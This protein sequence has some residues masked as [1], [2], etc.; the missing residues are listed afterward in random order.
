MAATEYPVPIM[1]HPLCLQ[2]LEELL[3]THAG[4]RSSLFDRTLQLEQRLHVQ[5]YIQVMIFLMLSRLQLFSYQSFQSKSALRLLQYI[6]RVPADK[7][8]VT[9][10]PVTKITPMIDPQCLLLMNDPQAS[11]EMAI[12]HSVGANIKSTSTQPSLI[13][14]RTTPTRSQLE[15]SPLPNSTI[16]CGS[17]DHNGGVIS[18]EDGI[19][20]TVPEGAIKSGDLVTFHIAAGLFG[21]F[22]LLSKC[23]ANLASPYY[24]IGVSGSYHFHKPVQVEFEHFGACDPS[25]YQLLCCEDDDESCTLRPVDYELNFEERDGLSLCTFYTHHFCSYCL[26]HGCKDPKIS[27]IV[28]LY[29]RPTNFQYLNYFTVEIWFSLPISYCLKRSEELFRMR[30]MSLES[31]SIFVAPSKKHSTIYFTLN[32]DKEINGWSIHHSRSTIIKTTEVNFYNYNTNAKDLQAMEEA[33][34]FPP[35]FV[36][37]VSKKS[38]CNT[39]LNTGVA[40]TLRDGNE[41]KKSLIY[42]LF[43]PGNAVKGCTNV[44][45]MYEVLHVVHSFIVSTCSYTYMHKAI[46]I[47]A[48]TKFRYSS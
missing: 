40:I 6:D 14:A 34:L 20:I 13:S 46:S 45:M 42:R 25:H 28:A 5:C 48:Q 18:S 10:K 36:I 8:D 38:D 24:W 35:R 39:E 9:L 1:E 44:C 32:Y 2:L 33:S 30:S 19:K 12:Y 7:Y 23:Q 37:N 11:L 4:V 16:V 43:A 31:S 41:D 3:Q 21:P 15:T 27:R 29:L 26:Y 17:C 22:V 47:N